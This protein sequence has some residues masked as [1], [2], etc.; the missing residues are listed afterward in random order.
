[1]NPLCWLLPG[2]IAHGL[3]WQLAESKLQDWA[4]ALLAR[5]TGRPL[6]QTSANDAEGIPIQI[7]RD[8]GRRYNPLF[9]AAQASRDYTFRHKSARLSNFRRLTDWLAGAAQERAGALWLP[10][11]FPLPDFG[12]AP[13]WYSCLAQANTLLCF[14]Q[15]HSLEPRGGWDKRCEGLLR[16]LEPEHGLALGTGSGIWF[17]EYPGT[18]KAYVLN[19]MI[20]VLLYLD[21][22]ARLLGSS[23]AAA[24][25]DQGY[26]ALLEKLPEF[27]RRGFTYYSLDGTL[28]SR[29]YHQM[30]CRLLKRLNALRPHP[31]LQK[32]ARRWLAHDLIPVALQLFHYPRPRRVAAFL[33]SLAAILALAGLI[34]TMVCR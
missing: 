15:R 9:I 6:N 14:A 17:P 18:P 30:H 1:M 5:L 11:R 21:E 3:L 31:V 28:A 25:F 22:A 8:R 24:L 20:S 29:N 12:L 7:Y 10:Y 26:A 32:Y 33:L 16:S 27:D 34:S 13:P 23:R 19:G 2:L 4:E